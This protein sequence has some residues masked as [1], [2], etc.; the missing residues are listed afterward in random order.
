MKNK[1]LRF[2][3]M[4]REYFEIYLPNQKGVSNH[5]IKNY[6]ICINQFLD[7]SKETLNIRLKD[8]EF[9][10]TTIKLVESFLEYGEEKLKWSIKTRNNKLAAI[11]SFYKYA[12]NHDITLI[13]I[14]LQLMTIPIKS[15]PKGTIIDYFSEEEL[16]LLLKQPNQTKLKD[17]RNLTMM[18][19]LYDTGAR[20]QELLD[21]KLK[22]VFLNESPHIT[23]CG[24][25]RKMRLVPIMDKTVKHIRRYL[26]DYNLSPEDYL[27]FTIHGGEKTRM[28][29]DTFQKCID[30]YCEMANKV[31]EK[32]PKHIY[33]HMFRHSRA[34]HL[35]R[36]GMPLPLVS[37]WLGHAQINTTREFYASADT[38][39]KRK[40]I[41]SASSIINLLN[42]Q[43]YEYEFD[44]DE[45]LKK[46]YSLK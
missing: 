40:A 36:N 15:A 37:E 22:D 6:K 20:I 24:K 5:T 28:N 30:Q 16:E 19:T 3:K 25:G 27:F 1:E 21:I 32:F 26:V 41:N 33:C 44:D 23:L 43:T 17:R 39:M 4:I 35:Y 9:K 34:M 29:P 18:V 7:Y 31:D 8:F 10:N 42:T 45:L 14:Y 13:D 38:E 2:F 12:A 46:L 11:R